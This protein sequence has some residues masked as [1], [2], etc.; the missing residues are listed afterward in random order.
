VND[1][2]DYCKYNG[3]NEQYRSYN[4]VKKYTTNRMVS[5]RNANDWI[6]ELNNVINEFPQYY[7]RDVTLQRMSN[8]LYVT[9]I[10]HMKLKSLTTVDILI[11]DVYNFV[12]HMYNR[13]V[14]DVKEL[15]LRNFFKLIS[16]VR[17][18]RFEVNIQRKTINV[19][20]SSKISY[21][22]LNGK[23]EYSIIRNN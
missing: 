19:S 22:R 4:E 5:T 13:Y 3:S 9:Y 1:V 20:T 14:S 12:K 7:N 21:S 10:I 2:S 23:I 16:R 6:D 17:V 8:E 18:N 11:S 15:N